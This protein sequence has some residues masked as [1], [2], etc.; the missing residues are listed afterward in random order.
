[1]DLSTPRIWCRCLNTYRSCSTY[2][3]QLKKTP[4]LQE[5]VTPVQGVTSA[6]TLN[7]LFVALKAAQESPLDLGW[8]EI[9]ADTAAAPEM[10]MVQLFWHPPG[11]EEDEDEWTASCGFSR[12]VTPVACWTLSEDLQTV[13][14]GSVLLPQGA[15]LWLCGKD[16]SFENVVFSGV[17][18]CS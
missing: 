1:M 7:D 12:G 9:I 17:T 4:S 6:T 3:L 13:C 10:S 8:Q 14:N 5:P 18:L 11:P 15:Q 16:L 2:Q